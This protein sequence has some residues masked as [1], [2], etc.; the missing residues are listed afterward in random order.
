M[1]MNRFLIEELEELNNRIAELEDII[2]E[3]DN[4]KEND[5]DGEIKEMDEFLDARMN[6]INQLGN[7]L[8]TNTQT[9]PMAANEDG[10]LEAVFDIEEY[11]KIID[12]TIGFSDSNSRRCV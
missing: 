6:T 11:T 12:D 3:I 1:H 4:W 2:K 8:V 9:I 10:I 5:P 7:T